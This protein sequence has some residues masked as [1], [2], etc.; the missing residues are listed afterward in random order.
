MQALNLSV[1]ALQ[2]VD[3][4]TMQAD[5]AADLEEL[6]TRISGVVQALS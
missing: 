3:A 4:N 6:R 1:A 2:R 5:D